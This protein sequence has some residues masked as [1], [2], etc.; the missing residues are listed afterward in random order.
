MT[1]DTAGITLNRVYLRVGF[2][3]STA[4]FRRG[5]RKV[6]KAGVYFWLS[7]QVSDLGY[8]TLQP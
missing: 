4:R 2:H 6:L 8:F 3:L 5:W 1:G 7:A